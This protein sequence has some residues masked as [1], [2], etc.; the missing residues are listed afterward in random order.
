MLNLKSCL[1]CLRFAF[2]YVFKHGFMNPAS[3]IGRCTFWYGDILAFVD[4]LHMM[5]M[6]Q[7]CLLEVFQCLRFA[8]SFVFEYGLMNPASEIG[9]WIFWYG[10]ILV[11][12]D[13]LYMM[14]ICQSC[15][16]E[17]FQ[18]LRFAAS[19]VF[20]YTG[21]WIW[22]VQLEGG[23]FGTGTFWHLWTLYICWKYAKVAL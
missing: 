4:T 9:R 15:L 20:E 19:F 14:K 13:T 6:C 18:C 16:L 3:E 1:Y 17:V 22:R 2:S 23:Y 5:K 11:F 8:A 10:D 12:V 7:S 21:S